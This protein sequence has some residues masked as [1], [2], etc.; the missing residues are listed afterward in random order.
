M[1]QK[2]EGRLAFV[3]CLLL[4]VDTGACCVDL[5]LRVTRGGERGKC[6]TSSDQDTTCNGIVIHHH[7]SAARPAAAAAHASAAVGQRG[8]RSAPC[9]SAFC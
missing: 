7:G 3:V 6:D 4:R 2:I 1:M 5:R 8:K 9:L